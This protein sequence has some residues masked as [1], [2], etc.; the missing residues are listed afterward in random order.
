[1]D[2]QSKFEEDMERPRKT[3][4]ALKNAAETVLAEVQNM[5]A[6]AARFKEWW[7]RKSA[8]GSAKRQNPR[9]LLTNLGKTEIMLLQS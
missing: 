7:T 6:A 4:F 8:P 9:G 2:N 3:A 5:E 1:M